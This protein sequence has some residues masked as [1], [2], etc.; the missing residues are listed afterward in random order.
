MT[1]LELR[2]ICIAAAEA[3]ARVLRDLYERPR[4]VHFKGR[5]DLVTDAD[6]ATN[7]TN[8]LFQERLDAEAKATSNRIS[9]RKLFSQS[10][11]CYVQLALR[12]SDRGASF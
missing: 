6:K 1:S 12:L 2:D 5:F 9:L 10:L 3:G 4:D 7:I 11:S 8:Y